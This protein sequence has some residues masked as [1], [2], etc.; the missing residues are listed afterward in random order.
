MDTYPK[1]GYRRIRPH[2]V[3]K[4]PSEK[5]PEGLKM[6]NYERDAT[7]RFLYARQKSQDY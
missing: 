7:G 6:K 3:H 2:E 4:K 1:S 5:E